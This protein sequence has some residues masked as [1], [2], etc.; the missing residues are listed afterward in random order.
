MNKKFSTLAASLMLAS[1]FSFHANA[2]TDPLAA[3]EVK[4]GDYV[5]L[6]VSGNAL[7]VGDQSVLKAEKTLDALISGVVTIPEESTFAKQYAALN[8]ALWRVEVVKQTS[9]TGKLP[10]LYRFVNKETGEY[11]AVKLKTDYVDGTTFRTKDPVK[12]DASGNN[13]WSFEDGNLSAYVPNGTELKDSTFVLGNGFK[14]YATQ[15]TS[16][17]AN[18]TTFALEGSMNDKAVTLN[19]VNFNGIMAYIG[20][21]GKLNFNND[22]DV[23]SNE[24]NVIKDTKWIAK[25]L[26]G[27]KF[28]LTDETTQPGIKDAPKDDGTFESLDKL[29]YLQ[30]DTLFHNDK[31]GFFKLV[32]D[33]LPTEYNA[34]SKAF[35]ANSYKPA[36]RRNAAAAEFTGQFFIANDSIVLTA[37]NMPEQMT[38]SGTVGYESRFT[39]YVQYSDKYLAALS[40]CAEN[41]VLKNALTELDSKYQAF[42]ADATGNSTGADIVFKTVNASLIAS[43]RTANTTS[44]AAVTTYLNLFDDNFKQ[45]AK[46]EVDGTATAIVGYPEDIQTKLSTV[47]SAVL[48]DKAYK[49]F[50][51][52]SN[53]TASAIK[54]VDAYFG[55]DGAYKGTESGTQKGSELISALNT[56]IGTLPESTD[57]QIAVR[58][59]AKSYYNLVSEASATFSMEAKHS[60]NGKATAIQGYSV[61][62][63]MAVANAKTDLKDAI[64]A[65]DAKYTEFLNKKGQLFDN[66]LIFSVLYSSQLSDVNIKNTEYNLTAVN[67]Y[68]SG[69]TGVQ[70][71]AKTEVEGNVSTKYFTNGS[72]SLQV[73]SNVN[74]QVVLRKLGEGVVLTLTR[75]G[76]NKSKAA[77]ENAG[78]TIP[79]IQPYAT[80]GGDATGIVTNAKVYNLQVKNVGAHSALRAANKETNQ[81]LVA[82]GDAPAAALVEDVDASNVYAQW[83]FIPGTAGYYTIQ[84]RATKYVYY[85]GPV[86]IV[87]DAN[88]KSVADTY[89]LGADTL[90]IAG[91]TLNED[92]FVTENKVQYDYS[93]TYYTGKLDGI[94]QSYTINPVSPFLSTL[95]AQMN[96]DSVMVLGDA[97]D[98]LVWHVKK[99]DAMT[100]GLEIAGL[101]QLKKEVYNIYTI[102][103]EDNEYY[104]EE[105]DNVYILKNKTTKGAD[106][107]EF[108]IRNV[109]EGQYNFIEVDED[110]DPIQK[111][112]INATPAKPVIEASDV[113][114]EKNDL[115]ALNKTQLN[116]YRKLT[117]EDGVLGNAK[118]Y[119]ENE[120][121]RYLYENTANIVANNGNKIAKDSLNFLGIYN[122]AAMEKN[123]ALFVDTAYVE[124]EGVYMPQ[125]MFA[126]GVTDVPAHKAIPCTYEHNHFDNAGNKVDAEHCSHA[127]PATLGYKAG[128]YLV[129]LTDSIEG[130]SKHPGRYDGETRLAF[131]EAIHRNAEDSLIIKNSKYTDNNKQIVKGEAKTY[132]SNDTLKIEDN[133]TK[134]MT[135]AL[136]IADQSTQSFYL[137]TSGDK[138][139]RILNGVPVLTGKKDDAAIFN[140]EATEENATANE[141]IEAAG[142]QVIGGKGAVTVQ[143]AAGK[144]ITVANILGQTIANQV[145]ASD[146]VT[147]AAPAGVIVVAVEGE[148]TKV[149]VK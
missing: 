32:K 142:V 27:N 87:K 126:L 96:K 7:T 127:T 110:G 44:S 11:L 123:A 98:G 88:G 73:T 93:G 8:K 25:G 84:N 146:N 143:G 45:P 14:L 89:V 117:A 121:N 111:M 75:A 144:V 36:A 77:L 136:E 107:A 6:N 17:D 116:K 72:N 99:A 92:N 50:L 141:A 139:V 54:F 80:A 1:A 145:A 102:D 38:K 3:A 68:V 112:T 64:K 12:L 108:E 119:M 149:V 26:N 42:V 4:T 60:V 29:N 114:S 105:E 147:I 30:V 48:L 140:I 37:V 81:Y 138:Y 106:A 85:A 35:A 100:Y 101:P 39:A 43:A 91:V 23:T 24:K 129:A 67:D 109:A 18:K 148:A 137:A 53:S 13:L 79:M 135:F 113:T 10:N 130:V 97:E 55:D 115:F 104:I 95:S 61:V 20:S 51:L 16:K 120:P 69:F 5:V 2:A 59:T 31:D 57:D 76:E 133:K 66:D 49:S 21:N 94:T 90:K 74:G 52:Q 83:A 56:A 46:H 19:A 131:V 41:T 103:G 58:S 15:G 125:Y 118:I 40:A 33:T 134:A 78:Y 22:K 62:D 124:R 82:T 70:Y 128:R 28:A 71:A 86:S 34:T 63:A 9:T 122:T 65:V 132:A 47:T